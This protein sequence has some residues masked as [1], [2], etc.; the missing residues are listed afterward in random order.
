MLTDSTK[1]H[2]S[3]LLWLFQFGFRISPPKSKLIIF[4]KRKPKTPFP[5]L[6]LGSQSISLSNCEKVFGLRFDSSL[7]WLPHIKEI[8]VKSL[9]ALN[10][11]KYLAHRV[12]GCKR[13]VLLPLHHSLV[14]SI[15]DYSASIYSL[16][17][18][19]HLALLDPIQNSVIRICT[20]AF[21]TSP[22]LSLCAE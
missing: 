3:H 7:S 19:S 8:R 11:L 2:P 5:S 13:K 10:V 16:A 1:H 12:T 4:E 6:L 14:R 17:P 22:A 21:R 15:L 9:R 18:H 20:G